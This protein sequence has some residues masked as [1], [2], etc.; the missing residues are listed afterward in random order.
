M[1]VKI[2]LFYGKWKTKIQNG[3][4]QNET[5]IWKGGMDVKNDIRD[6]SNTADLVLVF[7]VL[8]VPT[9]HPVYCVSRP[10]PDFRRV[11]RIQ[12]APEDFVPGTMPLRLKT[13][14]EEM[15]LNFLYRVQCP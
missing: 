6:V 4:G 13:V 3:G 11:I 1:S 5:W 10:L 7:L 12:N 14:V 9:G 8:L 2:C 15:P